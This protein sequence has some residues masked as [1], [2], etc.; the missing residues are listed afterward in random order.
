MKLFIILVIGLSVTSVFAQSEVDSIEVYLIDAYVKPEPPQKFILSFFTSDI[1]KS[2]VLID[3]RYSFPVSN[4]F[5]DMHKKQIDMADMKF[6]EKIVPFVIITE[7]ENG[8]KFT[9]ETFDFDLPFEPEI[10]GGSNL[11]QL[12][13]FGGAI[14]LLPYPNYVIQN[15]QGYF[16]LTKEIPFI[17]FR[18]S[19]LN[20]PFASQPTPKPVSRIITFTNGIGD[21]PSV[22]LPFKLP[23]CAKEI[24]EIINARISNFNFI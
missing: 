23:V 21:S 19:N 3:G 15:G 11:V 5:A 2:V 22:T 13:L 14:F 8:K 7:N 9:S 17:S 18:S 24:P 12:C 6:N 4:D 10:I 1:A 20:Y 16:S